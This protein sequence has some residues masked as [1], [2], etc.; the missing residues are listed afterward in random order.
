MKKILILDEFFHNADDLRTIALSTSF[1]DATKISYDVGWRG[2]RT[3]EIRGFNNN[4][5]NDC[6]QKIRNHLSNFF[7]YDINED[8]YMSA[9]FYFHIALSETKNTLLN[10]D[11]NKFHMDDATYAGIVY[12]SPNPPS[13]TGTSIIIENQINDVENKYNR[14]VAYP[15]DY[16]HAPTDL[17]GSSIETGRLT[18]SFF[19]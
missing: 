18:L 2:F 16:V 14:L 10:F 11:V 13:E 1:N 12:L 6:C 5:L 3:N 17:F 8:D 9:N 19:I 7:N 15:S 4:V